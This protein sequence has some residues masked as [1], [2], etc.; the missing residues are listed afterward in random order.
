MEEN[1]E[2]TGST[3][4]AEEKTTERPTKEKLVGALESVLFVTGEPIP[5]AEVARIFELSGPELDELIGIMEKDYIERKR[6]IRLYSTGDTLQLVTDPGNN[7]WLI[8]LLA[9]P[10][11]KNLSESIMETL[12]VIAYRQPVT[13]ADIEAVRGVRCEYAVSQLIKQG[14][15][16]E[17]GRKDVVGRPML[18]GTTDAFL[19]RFGLHDLSELPP[20]PETEEE[21]EQ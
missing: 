11:E 12:S 19:R 14:F 20:M 16:K 6:G 13:R 2:I 10:Q 18:F 17:L 8:K 1:R 21:E 3:A 7:E 4:E 9:P 5:K 15:I